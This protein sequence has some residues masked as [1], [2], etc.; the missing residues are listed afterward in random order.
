[1]P[2]DHKQAAVARA[3]EGALTHADPAVKIAAAEA[4]AGWGDADSVPPLCRLTTDWNGNGRAAAMT[5]LAARRDERGA[6]AVAARL[7]DV[8]D[9][10]HAVKSLIAMGQAAEKAVAAYLTDPDGSMRLQACRIL[11]E[12]G[13]RESLPALEKASQDPNPFSAAA[14]RAAMEAAS[15]RR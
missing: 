8:C 11:K 5:A 15:T 6:T 1:L 9:H 10:D 14:A 13:T 12:I 2:A 4:L 3:L 7:S